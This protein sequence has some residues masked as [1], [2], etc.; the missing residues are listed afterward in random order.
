MRVSYFLVTK[1]IKE[2]RNNLI[3]ASSL[4]TGSPTNN[5]AFGGIDSQ[6]HRFWLSVE[7]PKEYV[8]KFARQ[9]YCSEISPWYSIQYTDERWSKY[10]LRRVSRLKLYYDSLQKHESDGLITRWWHRLLWHCYWSLAWKYINNIFI[11][12]GRGISFYA[13]RFS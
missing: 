12:N 2:K 8:Q 6:L 7:T 11:Y 10:F 1:A 13:F 3:K 9:H 4:N 5:N